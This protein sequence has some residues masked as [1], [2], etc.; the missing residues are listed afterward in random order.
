[1]FI[2]KQWTKCELEC[3]LVASKRSLGDQALVP[4]T[5]AQFRKLTAWLLGDVKFYLACCEPCNPEQLYC[6]S[7]KESLWNGTRPKHIFFT[8]SVKAWLKR[9]LEV[10][11]LSQVISELRKRKPRKNII[12]DVFDG[13]LTQHLVKEGSVIFLPVTTL[14]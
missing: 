6:P 13:K 14:S 9:L 3:E 7:C 11:K 8:R 4:T 2:M 1:M 10:P 12:G 5:M